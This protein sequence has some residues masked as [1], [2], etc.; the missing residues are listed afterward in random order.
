MILING[1]DSCSHLRAKRPY[2]EVAVVCTAVAHRILGIVFVARVVV[3][4]A[5]KLFP[6]PIIIK[7]MI[8]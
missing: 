6:I 2:L 8:Y 1:H 7:K 3:F 5:R 4:I